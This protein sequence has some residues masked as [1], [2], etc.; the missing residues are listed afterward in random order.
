MIS[1]DHPILVPGTPQ[2]RDRRLVFVSALIT[3]VGIIFF[4]WQ[5]AEVIFLFFWEMLLIGAATVLR[6][7][8]ALNGQN[9]FY[10]LLPR[11]FWTV[12]FVFLYGAMMMLLIAF[13][14]SG[15]NLDGLLDNFQG[16]QYGVWLLGFNHLAAFVFGYILSGA[17]KTSVFTFE[18]FSTMILA[19]PTVAVMVVIIAPNSDFM[20]ADYQNIWVAVAIVLLRLAMEWLGMRIRKLFY[21]SN[22]GNQES[23]W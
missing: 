6:I 19:L 3:L 11:L 13:V 1:F 5:V 16:I 17:Y 14:L 9:F 18:L 15:L 12:G 21:S 4:N 23:T 7:L 2:G 8:L 22:S 10:G 20:G